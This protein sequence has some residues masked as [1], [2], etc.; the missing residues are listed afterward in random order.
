MVMAV[1]G[2]GNSVGTARTP[3][4]S[5]PYTQ[6]TICVVAAFHSGSVEAAAL[7]LRQWITGE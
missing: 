4:E 3:A 2:D 5:H 7:F 1:N 6:N